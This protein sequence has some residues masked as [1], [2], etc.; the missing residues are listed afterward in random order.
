VEK[1]Y[2]GVKKIHWEGVQF[3]TD[4]AWRAISRLK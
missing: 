1:A 4:I 3:R 2:S